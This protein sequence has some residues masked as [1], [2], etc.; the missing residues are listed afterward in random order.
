[1]H[2]ACGLLWWLLKL[3]H[4]ISLNN[5]SMSCRAKSRHRQRIDTRLK[6]LSLG[7]TKARHTSILLVPNCNIIDT[8]ALVECTAILVL[9]GTS[10]TLAPARN[11][12][13]IASE[14]LT[15]GRN[16]WREHL[17]RV[18][19][20]HYWHEGIS[21]MYRNTRTER[22]ERDARSGEQA[23]VKFDIYLAKNEKPHRWREHLAHAQPQLYCY[24][25]TRRNNT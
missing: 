11:G 16:R 22:H 17:A 13:S 8:I 18:Q 4:S 9:K 23:E 2:N 1:M 5:F 24:E 19:Q 7:L 12:S 15:E 10:V 14:I 20:Q 21:R 25:G 3:S 6:S